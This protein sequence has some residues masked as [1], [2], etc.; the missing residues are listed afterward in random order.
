MKNLFR[1]RLAL[2][3]L[4]EAFDVSRRDVGQLKFRQSQ[5]SDKHIRDIVN[6]ASAKTGVPTADIDKKLQKYISEIEEF[7]KYSYVLYDTMAKNAVE[8]VAFDL[9]EHSRTS[10]FPKFDIKIFHELIDMVQ[11]E[12]EQ[13]FPLRAPGE[14]TYIYT[15]DPILVPSK[16]KQWI[17][18]GFNQVNTA[19]A[20]AQG[21]FIF[22]TD[23]MQKLMDWASAEGLKPKANKYECNGGPIPDCYAYIEFLIVHE[24]LHYSYGDFAAGKRLKQYSHTVH[25]WASDFRSNY[26][27]VKNG[28]EQ[29]PLGLFSDHINYDR[30]GSYDD[31]VELVDSE[32]KKLPKPLQQKF[33]D[34]ADSIDD[35]DT[36]TDKSKE[37]EDKPKTSPSGKVFKEP[38]QAKA[39]DVVRLPDGSY[40]RVTQV[41]A[42]G[43]FDTEP[44]TK[45]EASA[46]L[47]YPDDKMVR[48]SRESIQIIL[49]GR[50]TPGEVTWMKPYQPPT[51]GPKPPPG[52]GE[53]S[54]EMEGE[55]PPSDDKQEPPESSDPKD[56]DNQQKPGDQKSPTG[57]PSQDEIQKDIEKKMSERKQIGSEEEVEKK[58]QEQRAKERAAQ[59]GSP[60]QSG[61]EKLGDI[62]ELIG[63]A[64]PRNWKQLIK[65][66]VMSSTPKKLASYAKPSRKAVVGASVAAQLGAG[67]MKPGLKTM[68]EQERKLCLVFDTSGSMHDT[69][70]KVMRLVPSLL[71]Q[72][73][74]SRFPLGVIF[75]AGDADYYTVNIGENWY[76]EVNSL[77]QLAKDVTKDKRHKP[78]MSIF[79]QRGGGGTVLSTTIAAEC[80]L[81][82]QQGFNIVLFSDSDILASQNWAV[83]SAMLT[84]HKKNVFFIADKKETWQAA[85]QQAGQ[86]PPGWSYVK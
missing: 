47:D 40:G 45:Q 61:M 32:L 59:S 3:L 81:L 28:Y 76:A 19:A 25:N 55:D 14:I 57:V 83:F 27:L 51:D 68:E 38:Y 22:N 39:G 13:F 42:D 56:K 62:K 69:I 35:H 20:T 16:N 67:A 80:G 36:S 48:E 49:E 43:S 78:Y 10:K 30:Q 58:R 52:G 8:N 75:F 86:T 2:G 4:K 5:I 15:F 33:K 82:A 12:H 26:M 23:F 1:S 44:L 70:V 7:K 65:E 9:I 54:S 79:Q 63:R 37:K 77:S 66:M 73:N 50:W 18:K 31:I 11:L 71:E 6:Q 85:C 60:G 72:A 84:A 34:L 24:L 46:I 21:D 29:L 74:V 17:E 53:D 41:D 64:E